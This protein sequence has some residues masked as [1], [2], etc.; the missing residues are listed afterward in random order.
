MAGTKLKNISDTTLQIGEAP[1][2]LLVADILHSARR[3]DALAE[4]SRCRESYP[5][6]AVL[7]WDSFGRHIDVYIVPY[8]TCGLGVVAVLLQEVIS[9]YSLLSPPALT[10]QASTRVCNALALMQSIAS[11]EET[12]HAFLQG[13]QLLSDVISNCFSQSPNSALPL[14]MPEY[15]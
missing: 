6:L 11:H 10:S 2:E 13:N 3:E 7:L 15:D 8:L 12:R 14:S 4:L 9:I 5:D 1:L